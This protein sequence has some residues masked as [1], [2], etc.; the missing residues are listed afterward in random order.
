MKCWNKHRIGYVIG[1]L[2]L[3]SVNILLLDASPYAASVQNQVSSR[4]KKMLVYDLE[5]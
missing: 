1:T 5:P 2:H 3:N 4:V